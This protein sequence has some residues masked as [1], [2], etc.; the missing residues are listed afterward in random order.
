MSTHPDALAAQ[1]GGRRSLPSL[2]QIALNPPPDASKRDVRKAGLALAAITA[3]LLL[4]LEG[5]KV[6]VT[7]VLGTT[8]NGSLPTET[9]FSLAEIVVW[10][11]L[12]LGIY[13]VLWPTPSSAF[14]RI[15]KALAAAAVA[16]PLGGAFLLPGAIAGAVLEHRAKRTVSFYDQHADAKH[17]VEA[18]LAKAGA[19]HKRVLLDFGAN[20]CPDCVALA[21]LMERPDVRAYVDKHFVVVRVDVERW[22]ANLDLSQ[23]YDDPIKKGIPAVVVL[24]PE[25]ELVASTKDGDLADARHTTQP[26]MLALLRTWAGE[27]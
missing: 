6:C 11:G 15:P 10:I 26:Q 17:D 1:L 7:L 4:V 2:L 24:T 19:E 9:I 14:V 5:L 18:A 3:P 16:L 12:G 23:K 13:R 21:R 27:Q 22:S 25:D 8:E 20:W